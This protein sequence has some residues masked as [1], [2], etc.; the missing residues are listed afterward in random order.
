M[1]KKKHGLYCVLT[2]DGSR[3]LGCHTTKGDATKQLAAIHISQL[4]RAAKK[5]R[6]KK[7]KR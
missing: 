7:G 4:R 2:R 6:G 5:K 1:I 3:T